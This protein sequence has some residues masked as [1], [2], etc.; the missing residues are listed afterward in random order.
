MK[1]SAASTDPAASTQN[2]L[3]RQFMGD[4]NTVVSTNTRA[5]FIYTDTR[6]GAGRLDVD[7]YQRFIAGT[8]VVRGDMA[9]RV[10][11]RLGQNPYAN[12][13]SVKPAPPQVCPAQFGNS[14][15]YVS[16]ITP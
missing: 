2:S 5:W 10:A 13:L 15:A 11:R 7:A 8:P 14:D 16:V 3:A 12:D 9:D 6:S 4:Y 1:A